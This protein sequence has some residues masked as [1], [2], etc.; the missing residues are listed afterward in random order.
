MESTGAAN[1]LFRH[2]SLLLLALVTPVAVATLRGGGLDARAALAGAAVAAAG[3]ALRLSAIRCIGK[4]A[5]VH[6]PHA[7]SG[8]VAEGPYAWSRNPLYIAAAL[9]L[10]GLGLVAGLGGW[11]LLLVPAT[12]AAYAPVVRVE[13]RA[14]EAQLGEPYRVY[15]AR[16]PRWLGLPRTRSGERDERV[17]WGEVLGRESRLIPGTAAALLGIAAIRSG[18]IP[19]APVFAWLG[20]A[21]RLGV[22]GFVTLAIA[23]ALFLQGLKMERRYRRREAQREINRL[24][25]AGGG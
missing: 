24:A 3:V 9:M 11:A 22:A 17:P 13:E 6:R 10:A 5:R 14:L 19:L 7:S 16:V 25:Q 1:F 2:R 20:E 8:L 12:I 21:T 18:W 23:I 15:A 4:G